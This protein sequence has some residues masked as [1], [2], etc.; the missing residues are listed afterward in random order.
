[1]NM[2]DPRLAQYEIDRRLRDA[3]HHFRISWG[4]ARRSTAPGRSRR[5]CGEP[6]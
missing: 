3:G 4:I 1:M 6:G 2:L 5:D